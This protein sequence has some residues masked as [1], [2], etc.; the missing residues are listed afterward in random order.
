MHVR[1]KSD[2]RLTSCCIVLAVLLCASALR[3]EATVHLRIYGN[4]IPSDEQSYTAF[5]QYLAEYQSLNPHVVIEDLGREHNPDKLLTMLVTGTAPDLIALGTQYVAGFFDQGLLAPVPEYLAARMRNEL[6]PVAVQGSQLRGALF[7]IPGQNNVTS[8]YFNRYL[9]DVL[10]LPQSAP[11]TWDELAGLARKATRWAADGAMAHP[12][13]VYQNEAW[14]LNRIGMPMLK[15]F[16]GDLI[17]EAGNVVV[18]SDAFAR[19]VEYFSDGSAS[20]SRLGYWELA[21][22]RSPYMITFS[23][24]VP[25]V[26]ARYAGDYVREIGVARLP[27]GP[28]GQYSLQYGNTYAVVKDSP[29][30]DEVWRLLEWL[31]FAPG[32]NGMTRMG[33]VFA[34]RGYPPLHVR[35]IPGILEMQEAPFLLGFVENLAIAFNGEAELWAAGISGW[36]FGENIRE[37]LA[38][39]RTPAEVL[40]NVTLD[41]Q[42]QVAES[43]GTR[44]SAP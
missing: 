3:A 24:Y 2:L 31:Y 37:L 22:G 8:L 44:V 17:D 15:S 1:Y 36:T 25:S 30:Q 23:F 4:W 28:A 40:Q 7:G 32:P 34:L 11:A 10:G 35:D 14:A 33:H 42:R 19:L 21:E 16:G 12:G 27:A 38:G 29:H 9:L 39:R 6:Y 43:R 5:Q 18:N 41:L 26:R 20:Y 13:L